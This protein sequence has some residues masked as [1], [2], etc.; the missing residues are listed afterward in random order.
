[1]YD[2]LEAGRFVECSGREIAEETRLLLENLQ[3]DGAQFLSDHVSNYL[4]IHGRL[5]EDK[6]SMLAAL[7]EAL[8]HPDNPL[9]KPR[10][11]TSL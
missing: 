8:S 11:I 3:V 7:D 5:P 4:P 9:L 1:M 6:E 2:D 10:T